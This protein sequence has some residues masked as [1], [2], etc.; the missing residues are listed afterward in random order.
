MPVLSPVCGAIDGHAA[1]LTA[2]RRRVS[3]DGQS[4]T[5][6]VNWGT[7][8]RALIALRTWLQ[9]QQGPGVARER[10][11]VSWKPVDHGV[12]EAVEGGVAHSHEVRQR[13][14]HKTDQRDAPWM[15]EL[16]AHRLIQPRVVP[17]P[18]MR[19]WRDLTR[20]RVSLVQTRTQAKNRVDKMLADPNLTLASVGSE[21]CGQSARRM[22]EALVAGARD[23]AQLSALALGS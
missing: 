18:A 14:G 15:A 7:P 4:T 8:S 16:L 2:C 10:T 12:R 13:P 6:L 20:T 19:A 3:D 9:A 22:L 21:G 1:Q 11:G 23:A 17:P 5:A